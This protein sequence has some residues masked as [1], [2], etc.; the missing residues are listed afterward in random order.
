MDDEQGETGP[1]RGEQKQ[2]QAGATATLEEHRPEA[3]AGNDQGYLFFAGHGKDG[4]DEEPSC[5]PG[6]H[7]IQ[8]E[9]QEGGG[10]GDRMEVE[11]EVILLSGIEQVEKD[12]GGT[13][14]LA[15]KP[16]ASQPEGGEG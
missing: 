11:D 13:G 6:V 9:E 2:E 5:A 3:K 7:E 1:G 12:K 14:P 15:A 16:Q 4:K 10:E 8:R